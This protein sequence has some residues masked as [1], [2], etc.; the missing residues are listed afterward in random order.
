[1]QNASAFVKFS[2][3]PPSWLK[4]LTGKYIT[5]E[6]TDREK[7]IYLTFDD[8]PHPD[9]TP[10]VLRLLSEYNAS[11]TFFV[12]GKN[13][14][15]Y[16][17]LTHSIIEQGHALGNHTWDH[18]DGWKTS[19][20]MYLEQVKRCEKVVPS[21]L[22]RPPYGRI[23]PR[24]L[25][26]LRRKGFRIIL[27]SVLTGDFN[28]NTPANIMLARSLKS[29]KAGSIVVLHDSPAAAANCLFLLGEI[30]KHFSLLG[31]AFRSINQESFNSKVK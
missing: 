18:A 12:K 9:V 17:D 4:T 19:S 6:F 2:H 28:Y 7:V 16:P 27:W 24:Q 3:S 23:G 11:A 15:E 29:I 8:G 21:L 25:L 22:F 5:W 1:M 31:F 14:L 26:M 20:D 30:L 13:A 10:Q